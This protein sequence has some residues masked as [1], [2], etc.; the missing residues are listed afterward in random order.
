MNEIILIGAGG[1]A[2]SCI[3]V[4]EM[5]GLFK[6]AGLIGKNNSL[7]ENIQDYPII[8][9]DEDLEHLRNKYKYAI[10]A[11]GQIKSASTR[12]ELFDRLI[13]LDYILP[14]IISPR[15]YISQQSKIGVGTIVMNDVFVNV[16][17]NI[18][19]NCIINNKVLIEH[20]ARIGNHCHI[21]TGAIINGGVK[22]SNQTFIGSGAVTKHQIKIGKNCVIGAGAT[23][24]KNVEN[25]KVV[26]S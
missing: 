9:I 21:S 18:G 4:I 15:S 19:K 14:S 16:N 24:N 20:D 3:E 1:H 13:K 5:N 7:K 2:R 6:V 23:I 11:V 26:I 12:A 22:V 17:A 25:D 8:G 10:I